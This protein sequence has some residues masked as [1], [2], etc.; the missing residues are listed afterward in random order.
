M[1]KVKAMLVRL[2]YEDATGGGEEYSVDLVPI[3]R[4]FQERHGLRADGIIGPRT[5]GWL[6]VSPQERAVIL[7]RTLLRRDFPK[8][9]GDRYVLVNLP[10][11]RLRVMAA[12]AEIFSSRVIVGQITRQTPLLSSRIASVVLNPPW[13]VPRS[14][15]QKD[16]V[17]KLSKS[18]NFV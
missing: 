15:L 12:G 6:R 14:I 8:P 13:S 17:P 7:A 4:H 5:L 10:E 18:Y 2:G 1:V 3:I 16:I 9:Q 11:Y